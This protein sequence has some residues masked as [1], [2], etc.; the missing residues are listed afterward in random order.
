MAVDCRR[1]RSTISSITIMG[2]NVEPVDTYK[3]LGVLLDN[4]LDWK[5]NAEA[6]HKRGMSRLYF[7]RRLRSSSVCCKMLGIF[8]QSVVSGAVFMAAVCWGAS[9]RGADA[10]KLN[11]LISKAGSVLGCPVDGFELVVERR[12]L[13]KLTAT[14]DNTSHPLRDLL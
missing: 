8:Y 13:S 12:S 14:L 2:Q 5:A 9:I 3:H 10:K 11:R 6:V 1:R 7:L 4:K